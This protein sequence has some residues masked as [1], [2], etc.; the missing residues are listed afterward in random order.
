MSVRLALCPTVLLLW[1]ACPTRCGWMTTLQHVSTQTFFG[2]NI[3]KTDR[4][5]LTRCTWS[6]FRRKTQD[7]PGVGQSHHWEG[8]QA[9]PH[10]NM[11]STHGFG[12]K[13]ST[14]GKS[15][16]TIVRLIQPTKAIEGWFL[17]IFTCP[18][19]PASAHGTAR[20]TLCYSISFS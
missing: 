7:Q 6:N 14:R 16:R 1:F 20:S 11:N 4:A 9:F 8:C 19:I 18:S 12:L 3:F 5:P 17:S 15:G 2:A 13:C 10:S